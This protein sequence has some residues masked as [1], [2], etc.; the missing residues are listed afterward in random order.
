MHVS[1]ALPVLYSFRRCPYA[2]R[3]R[4]ALAVS[5]M[6]CELREVELRG[7][8]AAMLQAS[9][10]GTVPVLVLADGKVLEQSLDI[11]HWALAQH[12]PQQWLPPA[13][14]Q[15][16]AMQALVAEC[17]GAFK[18]ALDRTKYP[19]RYPGENPAAHRQQAEAWLSG[20]E[21]RLAPDGFLFGPTACWADMAILPFVRQYAGI[22]EARWQTLP[23][24]NL[25][26]WLTKWQGSALFA[27]I[28]HKAPTWVEGTRGV[29]FPPPP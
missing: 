3:A 29:V 2:M 12:D 21:K 5:G 27:A 28:M 17:D 11:M 7:K 16:H 23:W 14:A 8:P 20:L 1:A 24:P 25:R 13:P 6:R 10:K 18:H 15:M 26:L 9:P 4:L 22:D 19:Q